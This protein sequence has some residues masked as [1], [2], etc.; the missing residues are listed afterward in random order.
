MKKCI[1]AYI[2]VLHEGYRAFFE[3]HANVKT[4]YLLDQKFLSQKFKH[5]YKD[6]RALDTKLIKKSFSAW[7]RFDEIEILNEKT[8]K[9]LTGKDCLVI[10]PNEDI[11]RDLATKYLGEV[12]TEFDA[13]FLRWDKHTSTKKT[14]INPDLTIS[15]KEFDQK[16]MQ[17]AF[18]ESYK[19]ADFWRHIGAV[20]VKD[21]KVL[22]SAHNHH[23]P[24]E[25]QAYVD[26]DPRSDYSKGVCI[27]LSTAI[28][29][30]AGLIAEAAKKGISLKN[31]E[32]Y[33]TT[34]PC[35]VCAKQVAY[36]GIK[37]VYFSEG[38]GVLDGEKILKAN[39][40]KIVRVKIEKNVS[41]EKK[42]S[43]V[44]EYKR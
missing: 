7:D 27:E 34:F 13:I 1:L 16:M 31:A 26:G 41:A 44:K 8:L 17:L 32:I 39:G 15:E 21:G 36:S 19:S 43:H 4:L 42:H 11:M 10:M 12:K 40:V 3:K 28:H 29:A 22:L 2:P 6:I 30:E 14:P 35:P 23:V 5:I 9:K 24:N 38:Y 33:V 37:K 25:Q 18:D 20:I